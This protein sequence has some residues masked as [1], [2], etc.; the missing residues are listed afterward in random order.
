MS[1]LKVHNVELGYLNAVAILWLIQIVPILALVVK[2][3]IT[4]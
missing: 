1:K 4:P 2:I 3:G